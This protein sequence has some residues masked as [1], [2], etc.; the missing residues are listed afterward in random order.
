MALLTSNQCAEVQTTDGYDKQ[1]YPPSI[2]GEMTGKKQNKVY[3]VVSKQNLHILLQ[4]LL[5][6]MYVCKHA[7]LDTCNIHTFHGSISVLQRQ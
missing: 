6:C 1:Q 3:H 2:T 4:L 7:C 5:L